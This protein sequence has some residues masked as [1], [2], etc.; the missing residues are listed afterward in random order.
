MENSINTYGYAV[1]PCNGKPL[2]I[3]EICHNMLASFKVFHSAREA[4]EYINREKVSLGKYAA[5]SYDP[6]FH[7]T[8]NLL[9]YY[10]NGRI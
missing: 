10:M 2:H 3:V 1:F 6:D 5:L 8:E 7:F 4:L 9:N